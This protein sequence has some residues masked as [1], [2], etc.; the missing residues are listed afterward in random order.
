MRLIWN[1]IWFWRSSE[2]RKE[3]RDNL[4]QQLAAQR[5]RAELSKDF[6]LQRDLERLAEEEKREKER[7]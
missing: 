2:R 3:V 1:F 4:K 7:S 5:A 6:I